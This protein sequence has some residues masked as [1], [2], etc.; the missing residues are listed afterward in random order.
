[1]SANL[2]AADEPEKGNWYRYGPLFVAVL[3]Y[4]LSYS[5][6]DRLLATK[7]VDSSFIAGLF[8][9]LLLYPSFSNVA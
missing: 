5:F 1:M 4:N 8:T 3:S 9:M 6:L 7:R 2:Q